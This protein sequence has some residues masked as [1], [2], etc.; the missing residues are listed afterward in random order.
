MAPERG[1]RVRARRV[2]AVAFLIL[3]AA[4]SRGASGQQAVASD[5]AAADSVV[6]V[7]AKA[8]ISPRGAMLRSFFVPG[9]GQG[10]IGSYRRGA[11]FF[12]LRVGAGY[13]LFKTVGRLN[14]ARQIVA[15]GEGLAMDSLDAVAA[16]DARRW[17]LL[18]DDQRL[19][20]PLVYAAA[21]DSF[22]GLAGARSLVRAREQ[23][24]QDWITT[25][26]V[27]TLLDGV[28]AYVNAQFAHFPV[29]IETEPT[30]GGGAALRLTV[31]FP[32]GGARKRP[33][34]TRGATGSPPRSSQR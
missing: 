12:S 7:T 6:A 11:I 25:F 5:S 4:L 2:A 14:E 3:L 17:H 30:P 16:V 9:L 15:R 31:P 27:M 23:Q 1:E 26:I 34:P 24:R 20:D 32:L 13:M 21:V 29:G 10:T 19:S 22:P 33:G 18:T 28:D 8:G